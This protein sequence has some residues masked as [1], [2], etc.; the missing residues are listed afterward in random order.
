MPIHHPKL[1]ELVKKDARFPYEAYE[2]LFQALSYTQ[3]AL[4]KPRPTESQDLSVE[5]HVSGRQLIEGIRKF[6]QEEFGLMARCVFGQWGIKQTGDFG[7][8][9]F[10]LVE[11]GLMSKTDND[12]RGDFENIF[13]IQTGLMEGYKILAPNQPNE[14]AR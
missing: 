3:K 8:M 7:E 13:D 1:D 2:F 4:G 14:G 5:H 12:N 6:A 9:V 11:M 10:N